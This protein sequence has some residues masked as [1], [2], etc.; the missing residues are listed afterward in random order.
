[1]PPLPD[2]P[3]HVN[4]KHGPN[5]HVSSLVWHLLPSL[6][7]PEPA[8]VP[9]CASSEQHSAHATIYINR[10]QHWL[11]QWSWPCCMGSRKQDPG[12]L[13]CQG[14][15]SQKCVRMIQEQGLYTAGRTSRTPTLQWLC[16]SYHMVHAGLV[17]VRHSFHEPSCGAGVQV[18]CQHA[19]KRNQLSINSPGSPNTV[20]VL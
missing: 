20:V 5:V 17:G 18:H 4:T 1:M 14:G 19:N 6:H 2:N 12:R 11:C 8:C 10:V 15:K 9:N 7:Q 16:Q 3:A 13:L